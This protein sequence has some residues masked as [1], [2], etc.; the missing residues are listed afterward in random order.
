[1]AASVRLPNLTADEYTVLMT[2]LRFYRENEKSVSLDKSTDFK[3][4]NEARE[5]AVRATHLID[6]LR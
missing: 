4:K 1:M 2:A 3:L 6:K 5:N